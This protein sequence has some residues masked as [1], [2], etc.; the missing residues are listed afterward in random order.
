M[1]SALWCFVG[2]NSLISPQ[3]EEESEG[4]FGGSTEGR[5]SHLLH[6][7]PGGGGRQAAEDHTGTIA[8]ALDPPVCSAESHVMYL[9]IGCECQWCIDLDVRWCECDF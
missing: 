3:S 6:Q 9:F 8:S 4:S 5:G 7:F 1:P 2:E